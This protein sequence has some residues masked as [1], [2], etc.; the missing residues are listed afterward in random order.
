MMGLVAP[1][2][3]LQSEQGFVLIAVLWLLAALA[4]L[5][6]IFS[7]YV[8]NAAR[9]LSVNDTAPQAE[10]LVSACVELAVYQL[11]LGGEEARPVQGAFHARLNGAE[12]AVSFVS[13][14]ARVDLNAAPKELLAGLLSTLGASEEEAREGADRI[15]AWRSRATP[16]T[17]GSEDALYRAAG[18]SYSPRQAPFAHVNELG[19]VLGLSPALVDRALPYVT[20]FSGAQGIDATIA[21]PEVIAALPG[22]TPLVLKQFLADRGQLGNDSAAIAAALGA[23]KTSATAQKSKAYR[24]IARIRF[25]N[26]IE[27][28]SEVAI[29]LG[30]EE[31]PYRVLSWQ[32][33]VS[34][35]RRAYG[36]L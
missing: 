6:M 10:S 31:E 28:A 8:S 13:E 20:V 21:A 19:L 12:L 16:E 36:E 2:E 7:V 14:T 27:T 32:D 23:A 24:I 35:R 4:A 5:A 18:R 26:G 17:A 22:M 11:E 33:N 9:A 30:G 3:K 25:S 34:T 29:R 15:I 1:D